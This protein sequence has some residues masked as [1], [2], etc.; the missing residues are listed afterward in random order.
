LNNYSIAKKSR[1]EECYLVEGFFDVISL[2]KLGIENCTALLG[3]NLSEE[4]IKLLINLKKRII[5]FLDSDKAGQEATINVTV[6]L[7]L[8]EVDCE[9]IRNSYSG[10]PDE[11]CRQLDK[12]MVQTILQNREN[13][14]LFILNYYFVK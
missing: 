11:I 10:D 3:T 7:L 8:Q 6:K 1:A 2:T 13:P 9:I 5:L 4:Q 12:E 14:Y